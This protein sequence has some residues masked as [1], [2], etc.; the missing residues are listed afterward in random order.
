MTPLVFALDN[1]KSVCRTEPDLFDC[2]GMCRKKTNENL[3]PVFAPG[4]KKV[5]Q[6]GHNMLQELIVEREG[7]IAKT[8][9]RRE[10][11]WRIFNI[12]DNDGDLLNS[13]MVYL[14]AAPSRIEDTSWIKPGKV[15]WEW[16]NDWNLGGV[17][18]KTGVNNETYKAYIDFASKYDI[19]YVI[20]DEGW[21]VTK[22]ADLMQV[23]P[24]INLPE[25]VQYAKSKNVD[26]ILWAGYLAY[27]KDMRNVTKH[28]SDMGIKGFKVDFMDRDDQDMMNFM[29]EASEIC[30][31]YN[32]LLDFHGVSK[33]PGLQRT[34]PN[35]LTN[36]GVYGLEQVQ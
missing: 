29:L 36:E 24:E 32:M 35:L 26:L 15:A 34:Y 22:K 14:L 18:F 33:P 25:L 16:W 11:P 2:T 20:L 21:S 8:E 30:A 7:Y 19:P 6:G 31:E 5:K 13:D 9:G 12:S 23:V 17:D 1:V 4:P 27:K 28:Y 3:T 10:F